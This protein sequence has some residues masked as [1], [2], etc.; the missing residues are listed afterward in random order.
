MFAEVADVVRYSKTPF[1]EMIQ[2]VPK[3]TP[4]LARNVVLSSQIVFLAGNVVDA[5]DSRVPV[6]AQV[7]KYTHMVRTSA[8]SRRRAR[9]APAITSSWS[10]TKP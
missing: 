1:S 8:A 4:Q 5:Y 3:H 9:S 7:D 6:L 2:L 10:K